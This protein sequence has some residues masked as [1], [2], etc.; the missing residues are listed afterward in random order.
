MTT[1][2]IS[3]PTTTDPTPTLTER[4]KHI[5][6]SYVVRKILKAIV[7]AWA[8]TTFT[9]FLIRLLPGNPIEQ[10][11]NQLVTTYGIP[12]HEALDQAKALF[13]I[14]FNQPI[15][16]QY[17]NFMG[18]LLNGNMGNSIL[19]PGTPV[20]DILLTWLPW[21]VFSVGSGLIFSF[22]IGVILGLLMA[23]RRD[24]IFD[25]ILTIYASVMTSV[26]NYLIALIVVLYFGTRWQ[27][28]P[29]AQMRGVLSPGVKPELSLAFVQDAI[30][31]AFLPVLIYTIT[32][33]GG[34]MLTMKSSTIGVLEEDYVTISRAKGLKD[35]RI[36][37]AY[38]GRNASLPIFTQ[39]AIA[40]G[41]IV[42]G[43][44]IIESIF[45]YRGLGLTLLQ[46][47]QRRDYTVMQG[48]FLLLT[49]SVILANLMADI[50]YSWID[51]RIR[52]EDK[53]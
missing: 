26:P 8:V 34:W 42:G 32:G 37:S 44:V 39:L 45:Q 31:H 52:L 28:F 11:T 22:L 3:P 1:P 53:R 27:V 20:T 14:D 29:I 30:F 33:M 17:I 25:H 51:P 41:F 36:L 21:T 6:N 15:I 47:V 12:Y 48:G 24:S 10:Y 5:A 2:A 38:V 35:N 23:Y 40:I 16:Y 7:T 9:F 43:S 49:F 4:L 19:S 13:A 18:N 50:L 46:S